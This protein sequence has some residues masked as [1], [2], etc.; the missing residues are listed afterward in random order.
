MFI[1]VFFNTYTAVNGFSCSKIQP[2]ILTQENM[3]ENTVNARCPHT[4]CMYE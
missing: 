3:S 1:F 2:N 4:V